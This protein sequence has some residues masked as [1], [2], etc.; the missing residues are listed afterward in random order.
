MA[1]SI[2]AADAAKFAADDLGCP[3]AALALNGDA[4]EPEPPAIS[5]RY[6]LESKDWLCAAEDR[7]LDELDN[8][9]AHEVD[10]APCIDDPVEEIDGNDSPLLE[11]DVGWFDALV[12]LL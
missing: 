11:A 6:G 2:N 5:A 3:G 9:D 7:L 1:G 8:E 4:E 10:A 12:K